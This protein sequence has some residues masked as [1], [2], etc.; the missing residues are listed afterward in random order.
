M[1]K[2]DRIE[3][4][5]GTSIISLHAT[6]IKVRGDKLLVLIDGATSPICIKAIGTTWVT[7]KN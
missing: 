3:L 5:T 4:T 6:I 1:K 7:A 2:G